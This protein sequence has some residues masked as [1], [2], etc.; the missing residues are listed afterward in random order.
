[1]P[2]QCTY[3]AILFRQSFILCLNLYLYIWYKNALYNTIYLNGI[4]QK[5]TSLKLQ[6]SSTTTSIELV[7]PPIPYL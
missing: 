6:L 5:N 3:Q 1:M 2:K 7:S 4:Q